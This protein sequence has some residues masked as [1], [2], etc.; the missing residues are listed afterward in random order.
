MPHR[1]HD[2]LLTAGSWLARIVQFLMLLAAAAILIALPVLLLNSAEVER[3]L[4]AQSATFGFGEL[5]VRLIPL[6]L[7]ALLLVG[8]VYRFA[9]LVR[10]IIDTVADGDPFVPENARR[11]T[12][13]GWLAL[14]G[15][16]IAFGVM[17]LAFLLT[18]G[19]PQAEPQG[20]VSFSLNG[21]I[22]VIILFILARVFRQGAAM[23]DDLEGT[24]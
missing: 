22:L 5:M 20:E 6:M 11:L 1:K 7:L 17:A 19:F 15:Q 2:P 14:A 24:V 9:G 8:L 21:V 18:L 4:V 16:V 12:E 3:Q 23:R 13:M 10:S